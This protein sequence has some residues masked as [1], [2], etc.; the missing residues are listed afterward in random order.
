MKNE[1]GF[2]LIELLVVIA[3]LATLFGITA[4]YL[5]SLNESGKEELAQNEA[6]ILQSAIDIC[7]SKSGCTGIS[8]AAVC[9]QAGGGTTYSFEDYMRRDTQFYYY[10]D[11]SGNV[12]GAYETTADCLADN[13]LWTP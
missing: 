3:I 4:L 8:S 11:S 10:W 12:T 5:G 9:V 2:T 13:P 1:R 6:A 7:E